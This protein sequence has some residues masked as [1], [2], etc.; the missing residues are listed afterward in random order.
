[1]ARQSIF[2]SSEFKKLKSVK[3]IK[4]QKPEEKVQLRV[5]AYLKKVYPQIIFACD[6]ASGMNLGKRIGGMNTR[7]RSSRAL[8][9][10]FIASIRDE[11]LYPA[12]FQAKI[13]HGLFIELKK[14]DATVFLKN[15]SLSADKHIREQAAILE[16]LRA[17][18]YKAEFG[19]GFD[20]TVKIIDEYLEG[21]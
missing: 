1:M 19:V 4:R 3:G 8:P 18:G 6:L 20:A 5:C 7:L 15:G 16:R 12:N 11:R 10:L 9:D 2:T 17:L 13:Y 14:E 21:K